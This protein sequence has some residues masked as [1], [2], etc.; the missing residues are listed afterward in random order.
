MKSSWT[1]KWCEDLEF[2]KVN[3]IQN[4]K[5]LFFKISEV[6]FNEM[7]DKLKEEVENLEYDDMKVEISRIVATVGDA[8]T[9]VLFPVN[10]YLPVKFYLFEDG[11][12]II[13][14]SE[15]YKDLLYKKWST[16]KEFL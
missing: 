13:N 7:I 5:N 8:H 11:V 6:E 14:V 12:Y 1:E 10:K 9:A 4:H 16:L 2:L 3:L 15:D